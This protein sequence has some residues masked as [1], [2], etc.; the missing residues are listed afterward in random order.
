MS[1]L[2]KLERDV[3]GRVAAGVR[4]ARRTR[5]V[6]PACRADGRAAVGHVDPRLSDRHPRSAGRPARRCGCRP[7]ST[8]AGPA[9][10]PQEEL[11]VARRPRQRAARHRPGAPAPGA[12]AA[13]ATAAT[14]SA[15]SSGSRTTPPLPTPVLAHLELRL[16]HQGQVAVLGA[17]RAISASSTSASE[18]N[19]RSPTT[20]STGPP[21]SSGVEL[22]DVRPVV[23]ARPGRPAAAARPAGRSRRRPPPPRAAPA[24]SSTSV[25]PP[26]DAPASR[27]RRPGHDQPE[28]LERRQRPGQLVP[29][30]GDVVGSVR[31][32][33]APR[34]ATSVVTW[35][36]GL[37]AAGAGHAHPAGRDQL[38][39][40]LARAGQAAADQLGVEPQPAWWHARLRRGSGRSSARG[41]PGRRARGAA[42]PGRSRRRPRAPRSA[43]PRAPRRPGSRRPT[44]VDAGAHPLGRPG[45][46]LVVARL[47]V[48]LRDVGVGV[49]A[50][51]PERY[52]GAVDARP[53]R[54]GLAG[55][56]RG[57]ASAAA[58]TTRH[59]SSGVA[60]A[61]RPTSAPVVHPCGPAARATASAATL[62]R[63]MRLGRGRRRSGA[64]YVGR[65]S[66]RAATSSASPVTPVITSSESSPRRGR[67]RCRCRAGR[68]PSAA[69]R[70]RTRRTVSSSSGRAGLPATSGRRR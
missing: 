67:P 68:R 2:Q 59:Q 60:G 25:K 20:R 32:V 9:P 49:L 36:A 1:A 21:I 4:R 24:R 52:P 34:S 3:A 30:A 29:A 63:R 62:G 65:C 38:G 39:G 57:A 19:D 16:H 58:A 11:D 61:R 56:R 27:Q 12:A 43:A 37:V 51:W 6:A 13:S 18:M 40:V 44:R 69:A 55:R 48:G 22:A 45:L 66:G 70:H 64:T 15:R 54:R 14:A 46:G 17:S 23:H 8:S 42:A 5:R 41:R 33:G 10:Q 26:V 31:V 35:V 53:V 47:L 28:R 7:R 50:S